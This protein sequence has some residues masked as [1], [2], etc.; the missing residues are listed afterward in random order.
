MQEREHQDN[1]RRGVHC[2]E[3]G[4]NGSTRT[5]GGR[6]AH[7]AAARHSATAGL[8]KSARSISAKMK[9]GHLKLVKVDRPRAQ[10]CEECLKLGATWVHLRLCRTCGHVGCCDDSKNKHATQHFRSSHHP[11]VTSLEP[12]EDWSWCYVDEVALEIE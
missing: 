4:R 10:G 2:R 5:S 7:P 3:A 6:C 12:G 11:I 9:C 1:G 8:P